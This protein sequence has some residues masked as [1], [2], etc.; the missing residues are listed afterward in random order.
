M[1]ARSLTSQGGANAAKSHTRNGVMDMKITTRTQL[2]AHIEAHKGRNV[3]L[4]TAF[5]EHGFVSDDTLPSHKKIEIKKVHHKDG[6]TSNNEFIHL[7]GQFHQSLHDRHLEGEQ[8]YNDNWWFTTREEAE[9]Y[10]TSQH[11]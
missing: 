9:V 8:T 4:F 3:P 2:E 5:G 10:L 1:D 11:P 6:T 7:D